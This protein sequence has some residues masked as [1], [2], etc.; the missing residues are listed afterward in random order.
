MTSLLKYGGM[1]IPKPPNPFETDLSFIS[2]FQNGDGKQKL[3]WNSGLGVKDR[4][5]RCHA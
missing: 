4:P 1:R 5:D 2:P 3:L